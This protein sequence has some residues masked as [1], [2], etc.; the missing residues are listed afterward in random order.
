MEKDVTLQ[1]FLIRFQRL[2]YILPNQSMALFCFLRHLLSIQ[3]NT[4]KFIRKYVGTCRTS[5]HSHAGSPVPLHHELSMF[6][7]PFRWVL[8]WN[9]SIADTVQ[10]GQRTL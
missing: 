1:F 3:K 8:Q 6:F 2:I 9:L 10:S 7:W 4:K 5:I